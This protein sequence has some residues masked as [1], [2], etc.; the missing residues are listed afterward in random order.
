MTY[1]PQLLFHVLIFAEDRAS[2][3]R[4][5]CALLFD[6]QKLCRECVTEGVGHRLWTRR[7]QR[8]ISW[9][10]R[11]MAQTSSWLCEGSWRRQNKGRDSRPQKKN[12]G[13][14]R[15]AGGG[16]SRPQKKNTDFRESSTIGSRRISSS[17][18]YVRL[19]RN[20]EQG[21]QNKVLAL[22]VSVYAT[23]VECAANGFSAYPPT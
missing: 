20:P 16:D 8:R 4:V 5:H 14:L 10:L 6:C 9:R 13:P 18:D 19:W 2:P 3:A 1:W 7:P 12:S 23:Q 22:A 11:L 17:L 21:M 15:C